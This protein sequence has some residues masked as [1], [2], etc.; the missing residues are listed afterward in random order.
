MPT[1]TVLR[2]LAMTALL[3][4]AGIG[5]AWAQALAL[6]G[7]S[8]PA[9]LRTATGDEEF[10]RHH[11][12][13]DC[14]SLHRDEAPAPPTHLRGATALDTCLR[15]HAGTPGIPDVIGADVNGLLDRAAGAFAMPGSAAP[16]GHALGGAGSSPGPHATG[17]VTCTDCHDPHGNG[18]PR[19]LRL[20]ATADSRDALGLLVAPQARGLQRYEAAHV[21]YGADPATNMRAVS[22]L[23]LDCHPMESNGRGGAHTS[24][25]T[26]SRGAATMAGVSQGDRRGTT[27]SG[28]WLGG[29]GTGF[30]VPRVRVLTSPAA[31]YDEA[32]AISTRNQVFCLTCH[33]AH[34]SGQH[35]A[36]AWRANA[37]GSIGPA[38]CNQCHRKGV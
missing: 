18:Q 12:C 30:E 29:T 3:P 10:K 5:P 9:L 20:P 26:A 15:C 17:A 1:R 21:A 4:L 24:H 38:G 8:R 14:H 32:R 19:S 2:L 35:G 7:D 33:K 34:G 23:C 28:H 25:P 27:D 31:T 36:L 22:D 37:D 11:G 16:G 13:A 6:A